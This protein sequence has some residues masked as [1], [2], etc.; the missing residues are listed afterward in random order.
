M[1]DKTLTGNKKQSPVWG[2]MSRTS[3][4]SRAGWPVNTAPIAR[5]SSGGPLFDRDG[6]VIGVTTLLLSDA[7][8]IYFSIGAGD[9]SR[10]IRAP[11]LAIMPFANHA[12]QAA[13]EE[14][15]SKPK[16]S[17]KPPPRSEAG[18]TGQLAVGGTYKGKVHNSTANVTASF[19]I[20]IRRDKKKIYGCM[21][22]HRPLYGSGPLR[23]SLDG[24]DVL[25]DVS[26][27]LYQIKFQGK[28]TSTNITGT[29]EVQLPAPQ[30]GYFEL[31]QNSSEAQPSASDPSQCPT[32]GPN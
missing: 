9:V 19:S 1:T 14:S 10:L 15:A 4:S 13:D 20:T 7:P 31:E 28:A 3:P 29:Y 12:N 27:P 24:D 30:K 18:Q 8:G 22:I 26:G 25:F 23:G 6:K 17:V 16:S 2:A 11:G 32:D 5:G 21:L